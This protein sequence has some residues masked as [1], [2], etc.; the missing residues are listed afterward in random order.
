MKKWCIL[1][2]SVFIL[3]VLLAACSSPT[4]PG[5]TT[6]T[7]TAPTS[8]IP[9]TTTSAPVPT[10][11]LPT[12]TGVATPTPT[13]TV[14]P[15]AAG[16]KY[17]GNLR[18]VLTG[19]VAAIG[20]L[21]SPVEYLSGM[22]GRVS[23]P[24]IEFLF[25]YDASEKFMPQLAESWTISPDGKTLTITLR[26]GVKFTDG[27]DFN[28]QAVK[29][30]FDLMKV[31]TNYTGYSTMF[32]N[33]A[34]Y[35]VLDTYVIK[36]NFSVPDSLFM[37]NMSLYGMFSPTAMKNP[38]TPATMAADHMVGTGAFKFVSYARGDYIQYLKN[39]NYWQI[40][41][42]YLDSM[43][44]RQIDDPV[45]SVIYFRTGAAQLIFGITPKDAAGLEQGGYRILKSSANNIIPIVP[46]GANKDSPFADV[47][48]RQAAEY[49]IDR[50]AIATLGQGYWQPAFQ[51]A[52][53]TD[54][55]YVPDLAAR[56]FDVA[57][58]K[59][60]LTDAGYPNG[61]KTT[62]VANSTFD[63]NVLVA[64]QA[65]LKAVGIDGT[66]DI[67]EAAKFTDTQNKGWKGLLFS[68]TP[69]VGNVQSMWNRFGSQIYPSMYR[70]TFQQKLDA[71]IS[72]MDY[73]K[74]LSDLKDMVSVMYSDAMVIPLYASPDLSAADKT[75]QGDINWEIGHPNMW[76]PANAW[77]SP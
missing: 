72:E 55:R 51:M 6:S 77:L 49:A 15:S 63:R 65:Y 61:F 29:A 60:L 41:K 59:Q 12:A 73:D 27:T 18:I 33:V 32:K 66:I 30:D 22:Y 76:A 25:A 10:T 26:K 39:Q 9:P 47:K 38:T 58:A 71:A 46:D 3:S 13:K 31:A 36:V 54:A 42:P 35:E 5:P 57:K 62:L 67:Q 11:A 75:L 48:V 44:L 8:S 69:I 17:G 64:V 56:N 20:T 34:S 28:A 40:G 70:G 24:T 19:P 53:S 14:A 43:E 16:V 23:A 37:V 74:R 50:K 4:T 1:A 7:S 2:I 45:T 52:V 21:G 68:G